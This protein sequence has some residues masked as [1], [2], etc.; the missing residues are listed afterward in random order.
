MVFV[1]PKERRRYLRSHPEQARILNALSDFLRQKFPDESG[2]LNKK[3]AAL[4]LAPNSRD[5]ELW[6][7]RIRRIEER[8]EASGGGPL[9]TPKVLEEIVDAVCGIG[10]DGQAWIDQYL[11]TTL[12]IEQQALA[13]EWGVNHWQIWKLVNRISPELAENKKAYDHL[14]AW[15]KEA[16]DT[17]GAEAAYLELAKVMERVL[18]L[19]A[20]LSDR[21]Q[22]DTLATALKQGSG[23]LSEEAKVAGRKSIV[24]RHRPGEPTHAE[25]EV[26][27]REEREDRAALEAGA[28]LPVRRGDGGMTWTE[29]FGSQTDAPQEKVE[30]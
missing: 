17:Y 10:H 13:E 19:W 3:A 15:L 6:R 23:W 12:G 27:L 7:T 28:E 29:L 16:L 22:C 25:L 8:R 5:V 26:P 14:L 9:F 11:K 24:A 2:G 4:A 1:H 21:D 30:S 20:S 18:P